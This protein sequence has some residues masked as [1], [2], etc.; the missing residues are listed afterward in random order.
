MELFNTVIN[1]SLFEITVND[2]MTEYRA[3]EIGIGTDLCLWNSCAVSNPVTLLAKISDWLE[4]SVDYP[5]RV[6]KAID[7]ALKPRAIPAC[8]DFPFNTIG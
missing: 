7:E 8:T 2:S 6:S 4:L 3:Y 1:G 5:L